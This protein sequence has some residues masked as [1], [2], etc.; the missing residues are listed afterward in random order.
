MPVSA[1]LDL[2][3]I[4]AS[5]AASPEAGAEEEIRF[6]RRMPTL[7]ELTVA[8]VDEALERTGGNRS[9]A[10]RMLGVSRPTVARYA[11]RTPRDPDASDDT[12]G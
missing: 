6:P 12:D 5:R 1:F 8:A 9:V 10:A 7:R 3:G 11:R 2:L 4:D